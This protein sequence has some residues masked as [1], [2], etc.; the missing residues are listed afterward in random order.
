MKNE[1]GGETIQIANIQ[2]ILNSIIE[3]KKK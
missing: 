3:K 1:N 2:S